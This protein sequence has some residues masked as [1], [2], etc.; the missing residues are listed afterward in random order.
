MKIKISKYYLDK[1]RDFAEK[2]LKGSKDLYAYRGE[3]NLEKMLEDIVVGKLGEC[4]VYKY[5]SD[6]GLYCTRPDFKIYEAKRK[7]FDADLFC[8]NCPVHVK[9]Q[10]VLSSKRYGSSWLFQKSDSLLKCDTTQE[11]MAF[12]KVDGDEVDILGIVRA[13]DIQDLYG[14]CAVFRYRKTKVA[15]YWDEVK[16]T[17]P[18]Y[19]LRRL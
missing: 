2:Q 18:Y 1:C 16:S 8:E 6:R 4:A 11:F 14:E 5:L 17:L 15:L 13:I 9:S 12:T 3:H 10:S 7:S 19:K